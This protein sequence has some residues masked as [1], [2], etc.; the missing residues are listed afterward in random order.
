MT[1]D[2]HFP[3]RR[4]EGI[5]AHEITEDLLFPNEVGKLLGLTPASV[6]RMLDGGRLDGLR[7]G[8]SRVR[9]ITRESAERERR[10]RG[11]GVRR[12]PAGSAVDEGAQGAR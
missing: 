8:Q 3:P 9:L 10:R 2:S 7:V 1:G 6:R 4:K 5:V 12:K 11:D